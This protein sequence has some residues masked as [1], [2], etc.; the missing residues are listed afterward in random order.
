MELKNNKQTNKKKKQKKRNKQTKNKQKKN[1]FFA[2]KVSNLVRKK[3]RKKLQINEQREVFFELV[4]LL[5]L[6]IFV[7]CAQT[8]S[9]QHFHSISPQNTQEPYA[10]QCP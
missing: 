2:L 6:P 10:L 3:P 5:L 9:G 4:S 1:F 8:I 7:S